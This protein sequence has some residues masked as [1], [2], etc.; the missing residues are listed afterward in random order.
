MANNTTSSRVVETHARPS[1]S[2]ALILLLLPLTVVA[3]N[4]GGAS[5]QTSPS[6]RIAQQ[7]EADL[8]AIVS[9]AEQH[10]WLGVEAQQAGEADKAEYHFDVSLQTMMNAEIPTGQEEQFRLAFNDLVARVHSQ[11][12]DDFAVALE[13]EATELPEEEIPA[14]TDA[15]I[16]M[17]R[18][19][20]ED[21][22]PDMPRFTVPMP[23][24]NRLVLEAL[25]Y[26]TTSRKEVIQEGLA[27][28]TRYMPLIQ[29]VFS[30]AGLPSEL[31]WIP[32]I[33][34]LFKPYVRSRASA[35]G[36]WQ[37]MAPTARL[38]GLRVDWYVDERRDPVKAT[39]AI[40][41][42]IR[43]YYEEFGDWH[44]AIAAYNGG[45]G[46]VARA[47]QRTGTDNFWDLEARGASALPRETREFVPKILAAMLIGTDPEAYGLEFEHLPGFE[48][49]A[50][51]IDSMT[52]L[53]VIAEAAGTDLETI[54][55]LNP[56]LLR[57]TTPN[58]DS[59]T[60]RVPKG[61]GDA[62]RVAYA[63]IPPD[64]RVRIV[65]HRIAAGETLSI[66]ASRYGTSVAA[67]SDMNGISNQH[68]IR[69]GHTLLIPSGAPVSPTA[70]R[71]A[72]VS[73]RE[74]GERVVHTVRRG[75]SLWVIARAYGTTPAALKSW[76]GK[77]SDRIYQGEKLTVYYG[78]TSATAPTAV[79]D[80]PAVAGEPRTPSGPAGDAQ[81]SLSY[82]IQ[83]GDTLSS[84]A[85]LHGVSVGQ[86]RSWNGLRSDRIYPGQDLTLQVPASSAA[87]TQTYTVRRGDTLGAIARRFGVG[88]NQLAAWN[89]I[90]VRTTLYPGNR[91]VIRSNS[92]ASADR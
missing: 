78:T 70:A 45:K 37:L 38:Y 72:A 53:D 47:L 34:S 89:G 8:A 86:I 57:R 29:E 64:E 31:A 74:R 9:E 83:R 85:R 24:D 30:E 3:C 76:N 2:R 33:E 23:A 43:D 4:K 79:A 50:I 5:P 82:T 14:L 77:S 41:Q 65:E 54:Q 1:W 92:A 25:D 28:S 52:D 20:I 63:A 32:L 10:Y 73:E 7:P 36:L 68:R 59:F 39:Y 16:A 61:T 81:E 66:I 19:R 17:L 91:L 6:V 12:L 27:R 22:L 84:I 69:A 80:A 48:F 51:S 26:L 56:A 11:Q 13:A 44:L 75:E 21:T 55:E 46:R 49:D 88:V 58:V 62:F 71:T 42:F 35:V 90:S 15:E 67:I 60:I 18:T 87:V 40:A